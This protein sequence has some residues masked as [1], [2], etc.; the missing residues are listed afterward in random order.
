MVGSY[1]FDALKTYWEIEKLK[2][3][4][5]TKT[6]NVVTIGKGLLVKCLDIDI[7]KYYI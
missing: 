2:N 6:V 4:L 5:L 1:L 7:K 3:I